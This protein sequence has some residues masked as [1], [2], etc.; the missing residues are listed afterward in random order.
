MSA[1]RSSER[2]DSLGLF[3]AM[4]HMPE[5]MVAAVE[6]AQDLPSLPSA[7][8]IDNVL[9]LGV[10]DS[11]TAGDLLTVTAGPFMPV[12]VVVVRNY[13][14]PSYVNER[15]LVF[16]ISF[17]GNTA[18]TVEAATAAAELGAKVV[19]ITTGGELAA[20]AAV[21]GVGTVEIDPA[22]PGPRAAFPSLAV[23]PLI[24]LE[25]VGLFRGATQWVIYATEQ[26]RR[27][28]ATSTSWARRFGW[29]RRSTAPPR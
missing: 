18:E 24:V 3:D 13:V 20:R 12:P 25:D 11:G 4:M 28:R 6:A 15:T 29:P 8:D 1:D 23:A 7:D 22:I 14:P 5:Q 16:A 27:R 9:V 21:W 17:S 2:V 19:A 26:L 10:G